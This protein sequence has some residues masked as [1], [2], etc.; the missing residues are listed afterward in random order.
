MALRGL[1]GI[2]DQEIEEWAAGMAEMLDHFEVGD[3]IVYLDG[4]YWT[5]DSTDL[6]FD[7]YYASHRLDRLPHAQALADPPLLDRV[8]GDANYWFERELGEREG[9]AP[10]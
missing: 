6:A 3:I 2:S 7:G 8:L 9:A 4:A 1:H 10:A 5:V